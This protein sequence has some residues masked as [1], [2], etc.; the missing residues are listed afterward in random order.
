MRIL[1]ADKLPEITLTRLLELGFDVVNE[2]SLRE[3][4]LIAALKKHNPAVL[5]V[6]STKVTS[7]HVAAATSLSLIVRAGAGVNTIDLVAS[8]NRGVLIANCPG[9]NADAVAELTLGLMIAIDRNIPDNVSDLRSGNWNKQRY[10]KCLGLKSRKLGILG[11]GRIG[12]AVIQRAL[13][14]D[15]EVY[16]WSR[17]LSPEDAEKL[18]VHWCASPLEL[19]TQVDILSVHVALHDETRGIV[20]AEVLDALKPGATLINTSRAEVVDE[21]ALLS[22]I[23]DRNFRV[24]LDV[25][26]NEPSAKEATFTHPLAQHERVYGT[27]HIAAST[28]QAQD[29]VAMEVVKIIEEYSH[30][31]SAPN[32]VNLNMRTKANFCLIARHRDRVG[33]LAGILAVLREG[34]INVQEMENTIFQG[35]KAA[36]ARIQLSGQPSED[37]LQRIREIEDIF[38]VSIVSL[39]NSKG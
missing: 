37:M 12:L 33:V 8:S 6:R 32:C 34:K 39:S 29:A 10:S 7:E 19:A 9:K 18:G 25:F 23:D 21:A 2:P 30:S 17:S 36:S 11:T 35:G 38:S 1:L 28:N 16:A 31:G 24:G 26:S 3:S 27:H 22:R 14:F 15:M 5:V 13:A 20:G 4:T